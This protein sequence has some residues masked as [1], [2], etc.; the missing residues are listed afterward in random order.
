MER[1]VGAGVRATVCARVPRDGLGV[2]STAGSTSLWVLVTADSLT[3]HR[4]I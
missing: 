1:L 3:R 2:V 4:P